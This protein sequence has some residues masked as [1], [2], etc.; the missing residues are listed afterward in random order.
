MQV[1]P[2]WPHLDAAALQSQLH[3]C[4]GLIPIELDGARRQLHWQD[5]GQYHFY[6]G[7]YHKELALC[8][9]VLAFDRAHPSKR[10][11]TDLEL[12]LTDVPLQN[13]I[14]PTGFIF[15]GGRCGSSLLSRVLAHS[16]AHLVWGEAQPHN[17]LLALLSDAH[18][19]MLTAEAEALTLF[20]HLLLAMGRKRLPT[21]GA[22]FIKWTSRQ[23]LAFAFIHE[24]F[25]TVPK[26][27]LYRDPAAM[28]VSYLENSPAWAQD[29]ANHHQPG[30]TADSMLEYYTAALASFFRAALAAPPATLQVLHY[31]QLRAENLPAILDFFGVM[32]S[33][34]ALAAM[35]AQFHYSAKD[36][37]HWRP[38]VADEEAK[39]TK[40]TADIA[41][42]VEITLRPLYR[43]LEARP[44]LVG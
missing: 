41:A 30:T 17:A 38:F 43:Q 9:R 5:L 31:Q 29:S 20:R 23:I 12:L 26:L 33:A 2:R 25:P 35:Q 32:P 21:Y 27:F 37:R 39:A 24:A 4:P 6:Q 36:A 15:H 19:G 11:T 3:C 13:V 14:A 42:Q 7:F 1:S 40:I 18:H 16:R 8:Q 28:L 22:H 34:S 10:F 44:R